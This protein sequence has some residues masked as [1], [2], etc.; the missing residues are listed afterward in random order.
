VAVC[1]PTYNR[2][3][4]LGEAI[5]SV[6]TQSFEDFELLVVDD[7][8][9]DGTREI[10]ASYHD[11]RLRYAHNARNLGMVANWN[12][13]LELARGAPYIARLDDD[14]V[15][16]PTMLGTMVAALAA[17]PRAGFGYS[18]V[19]IM[20]DRGRVTGE[21]HSLRGDH[22][23]DPRAGFAHL[24]SFNSVP[25]PTVVMRAQALERVGPYDPGAGWCADWEMWLRL[26][27]F[28][29]VYVDRVLARYRLTARSTTTQGEADGWVAACLRYTLRQ[30]MKTVPAHHRPPHRLVRQTRRWIARYQL[31]LAF[32]ML[33]RGDRRAFR[34]HCLAAVTYA[35]E[36]LL[37]KDGLAAMTLGIASLRGARGPRLVWTVRDRVRPMR[38]PPPPSKST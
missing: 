10:V 15:Y 26:A 31:S 19:E 21:R 3:S 37:S 34:E 16:L 12:R 5:Q 2:A 14:D 30:A 9:T 20:D 24:L 25:T 33:Y 22:V 27:R 28:P 1:I 29:I 23:L 8:S 6:L 4:Y 35:P 11:P 7:G 17:D 38:R 32:G 18:A 36:L 13:C